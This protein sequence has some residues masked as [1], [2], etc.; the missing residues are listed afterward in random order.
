MEMKINAK[1]NTQ[2][3]E[4]IRNQKPGG[5]EEDRASFP[6]QSHYKV[7]RTIALKSTPMKGRRRTGRR[8]RRCQGEGAARLG[9]RQRERERREWV[10]DI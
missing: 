9:A 7:S 1:T 3:M 5:Y 8:K 10:R 2:S 6:N 4:L